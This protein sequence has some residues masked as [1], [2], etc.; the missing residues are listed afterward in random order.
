MDCLMCIL[1]VILF[2]LATEQFMYLLKHNSKG[3][4]SVD[5]LTKKSNCNFQTTENAVKANCS[6]TIL[7]YGKEGQV[8]IRPVLEDSS[9]FHLT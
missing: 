4:E 2:P 3:I 1:F 9:K 8:S 6:F 5:L 7:N